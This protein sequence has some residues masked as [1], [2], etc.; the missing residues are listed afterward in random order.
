MFYLKHKG[1]RVCIECDNV[2]THCPRCGKEFAADLAAVLSG[3]GDLYAT[4]V[5]CPKCCA[6]MEKKRQRGN[7]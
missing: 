5:Y 4:N 7:A 6:Q 1:S 3:G 2:Y